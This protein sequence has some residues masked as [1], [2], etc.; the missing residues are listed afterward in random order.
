[1]SELHN[2]G[3]CAGLL[4]SRHE[5]L[6]AASCSLIGAGLHN[7]ALELHGKS[8]VS[9]ELTMLHESLAGGQLAVTMVS[10]AGAMTHGMVLVAV[11][12]VQNLQEAGE[13]TLRLQLICD[14]LLQLLSCSKSLLGCRGP[15]VILVRHL[16]VHLAC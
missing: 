10:R 1:M 5:V 11:S 14:H 16:E 7:D 12:R 6:V 15:G 3:R 13:G 8:S 2:H 4:G 9:I